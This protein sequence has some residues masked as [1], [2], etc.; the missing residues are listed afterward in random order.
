MDLPL[1]NRADSGASSWTAV[2]SGEDSTVCISCWCRGETVFPET[3]E[4]RATGSSEASPSVSNCGLMGSVPA[5]VIPTADL[6][7]GPAGQKQDDLM[8]ASSSEL[9][10]LLWE[11]QYSGLNENEWASASELEASAGLLLDMTAAQLSCKL[12]SAVLFSS[13]LCPLSW[14]P[15]ASRPA[16]S[17]LGLVLLG[18]TMRT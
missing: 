4:W 10:R 12:S 15:S 17:F 11:M 18:W 16:S 14:D 8:V 1:R 9:H 5:L 7:T 13:G 2:L 3:N 6:S